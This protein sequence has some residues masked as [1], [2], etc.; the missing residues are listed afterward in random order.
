MKKTLSVLAVVMTLLWCGSAMA[1]PMSGVGA[2]PMSG[3][4]AGPRSGV[5]ACPNAKD[6][7]GFEPADNVAAG[8]LNGEYWFKSLVDEDPVNGVPGLIRYCIYPT[9]EQSPIEM[10][11]DVIGA[12]GDPWR[13]EIG[14]R[15]SSFERPHG[16]PSN[17]PLDG[18]LVTMG[19]AEWGASLPEQTI[20]L[21]INDPQI[22]SALYGN[23]TSTCF[24]KPNPEYDLANS[25][26]LGDTSLAYNAM[27]YGVVNCAPPSEA[28]EAQGIKE[29]GD[30]VTLAAVG[31][32]KE[33]KVTFNS[34]G[35]SDSG[36]WNLGVS[37]PC[38]TTPG[39]TFTHSITARI[40]DATG[41]TPVKIAEVT[42]TETFAYRP[43]ADST[44]CA[45][46]PYYQAGSRFKNTNAVLSQ[47][48]DGTGCQY[49]LVEVHTFDFS[50]LN[51]TL[52]ATVI[53]SVA[54]NTTHYG[55]A[56]IGEGAACF[57]TAPGCGYDSLNVGTKSFLNAPYSGLD[58]TGD[59]V[60][61]ALNPFQSVLGW[62]GYRPL[63]AIITK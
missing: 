39:A 48:I 18:T 58:F 56:P 22:C 55:E 52:P 29:F 57:S 40:Y 13:A 17:I 44:N 60:W 49:S 43:S 24:V 63:G 3:V 4:G 50:A 37:S 6:L 47:S 12:N 5:G 7:K 36:H 10:E 1:G 26:D 23:Y 20:L 2:G 54:Y 28:F 30:K 34:Y 9:P 53:W 61:I 15:N 14:F 16:N 31:E 32:L 45:T 42:Q 33:L 8:F 62:D 25:C 38:V 51:I 21:H 19:T 35:C 11:T 59:E 27:P 41:L 46:D